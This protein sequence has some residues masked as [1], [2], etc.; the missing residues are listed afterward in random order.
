MYF[1]RLNIRGKYTVY[2]M[3]LNS[4]DLQRDLAVQVYNS[5]KLV[6]QVCR[7]GKKAYDMLAFIGWGIEYVRK[8]WC[9]L[10]RI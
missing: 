10:I 6:T 4:I 9:R 2:G 5:L 1:A 7:V 3:T 8:S